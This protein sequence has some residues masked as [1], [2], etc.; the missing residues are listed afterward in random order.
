MP[1]T[2]TSHTD[3]KAAFAIV[4]ASHEPQLLLN[5]DH[6]V[7]AASRSFCQSFDLDPAKTVGRSLMD[8]GAGEWD[9][10]G[11]D[12]ILTALAFGSVPVADCEIVLA[13][14]GQP[15]RR[16]V[17]HLD[18]LDGGPT[19]QVRLLLAFTDLTDARTVARQ[20]DR[21]I[22]KQA[23]VQREVQHRI[24]NSLQI[25]AGLL[26][27]GA[28]R[29]QS[30]EARQ[31]LRDAHHRVM[32]VAAVQ[33]QLSAT[34]DDTVDLKAY[35]TRLCDGLATSMIADPPHLS[36]R[37]TIDDCVVSSSDAASLGLIV[38]ELVINAVKYAFPDDRP[39][40]IVVDYALDGRDWVLSVSDNGVGCDPEGQATNPGLG[41]GIVA[42]LGQSLQ[43]EV[44]RANAR[45]GTRITV[46][47]RQP[48]EA[49]A[50]LSSA[51]WRHAAGN[52][53]TRQALQ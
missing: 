10:P 53:Q 6:L 34:G 2:I 1:N 26:M 9:L 49:R 47:H 4:G 32:A 50:V 25:I 35:L 37:T 17:V 8:L 7:L 29:V 33:K 3:T 23:V 40:E 28:R 43:A 27:Q 20:N 22:R 52:A 19:D 24:A 12:A 45:P 44:V 48:L 11:F 41:T 42:A 36:I 30:D 39:G 5:A 51:A 31:C 14:P 13:R 18:V 46:A 38:T 21:L 15:I 16:L